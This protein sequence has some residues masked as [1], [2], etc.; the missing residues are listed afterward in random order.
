MKYQV[1]I[2]VLKG[3]YDQELADRFL[4]DPN[5]GKCSV[6]NGWQEFIVTKKITEI[7]IGKNGLIIEE[8]RF[9]AVMMA[10][11]QLFFFWRELMWRVVSCAW[12]GGTAAL[13]C[14]HRYFVPCQMPIVNSGDYTVFQ[15]DSVKRGEERSLQLLR[16]LAENMARQL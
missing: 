10:S 14:L 11:V 15:G 12:A 13:D 2:T 5:A 4:V 3:G 8:S 16:E 6:F 7:F 9:F 1:K